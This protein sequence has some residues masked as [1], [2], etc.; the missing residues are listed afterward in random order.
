VKKAVVRAFLLNKIDVAH[1]SHAIAVTDR[2]R[3]ITTGSDN[4]WRQSDGREED[5]EQW[6]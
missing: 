2:P 6:L 4:F 3:L 5:M 1:H